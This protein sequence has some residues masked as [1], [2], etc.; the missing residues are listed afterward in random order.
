MKKLLSSRPYRFAIAG[1]HLAALV[2]I[3]CVDHGIRDFFLLGFNPLLMPALGTSYSRINTATLTYFD[4]LTAKDREELWVKRVLMGADE[5]NVFSDNMIGG[6]GSGKAFIQYDDLSKVDGSNINIPT[7]SPLGGPG[8]QGESD[9]VGNEEKLR[10][11]NVP[12]AVGRQWYGVAITDV[13]KEE[14]V[15]GSQFDNLV[16]MMLRKRLGR[17]LS[18]DMMMNLKSSAI[19]NNTVRPNFKTAREQL[20][21]ADVPLTTTITKSGMVL[22]ALGGRPVKTI[23][24]AAGGDVEQYLFFSTQWGTVSL[25]TETAYLQALQYAAERGSGNKIFRGD[26]VD[27]NGHG[28]YRW[29]VRDH[30]AFGPV[31]SV[32]LP[33]AFLGTA[34]PADNVAYS[35]TGGGSAA[36][37]AALPAPNYFEDFS[38]APWTFTNGLTIAA[39]VTTVRY[40]LIMNLTGVNAGKVGFYSYQVNN[41][42]VLTMVNRLRA[43]AGGAA[44]TTLGNVTWNV[45]PWIAAGS[46][47]FAGLIDNHPVGSLIVETNS[48][49]VPFGGSFMLGEMAGV[50]GYGSLKGRSAKGARTEQLGNHGLDIGVGIECVFGSAA[51]QR[52]DGIFPNYVYIEHAVP[53]DGL[54]TVT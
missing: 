50:C 20:K 8:S 24:N 19:A 47:S 26:F 3:F 10:I 34:I 45:A 52:P 35:I 44:V 30:D 9:R 39:D 5:E 2:T 6:P 16:N 32:I 17:K 12:V 33:R 31:G 29:Y 18:E 49:G 36:A 51:M 27:W 41:G 13:A 53:I 1:L 37:T 54:P 42:Q 40:V 23:R 22:S 48:Y 38:N 21:T 11:G 28:I 7:V 15:I 46:G 25:S 43:V 4:S 14:T